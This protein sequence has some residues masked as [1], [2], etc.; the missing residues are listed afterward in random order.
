MN[1]RQGLTLLIALL[2][3]GPVALRAQE[4]TD[5]LDCRTIPDPP[6]PLESAAEREAWELVAVRCRLREQLQAVADTA[7]TTYDM[8]RL[9]Q[10]EGDSL[11]PALYRLLAAYPEGH[12]GMSPEAF[13]RASLDARMR[14][15]DLASQPDGV[16]NSGTL[17]SVETAGWRSMAIAGMI[18]E[19]VIFRFALYEDSRTW[20]TWQ[21]LWWQAGG[22][23]E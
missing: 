6:E 13:V 12:F 10:A 4:G 3:A 5:R 16:G 11:L 22:R 20:Q 21:R 7:V 18:E 1:R 17:H 19:V 23:R 2:T 9:Q 8:M 14:W 15:I